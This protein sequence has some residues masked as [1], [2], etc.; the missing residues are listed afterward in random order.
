MILISEYEKSNFEFI[1]AHPGNIVF[2]GL[3]HTICFTLKKIYF[4]NYK[5]DFFTD[6]RPPVLAQAV[7]APKKRPKGKQPLELEKSAILPSKRKRPCLNYG[8]INDEDF[9]DEDFNEDDCLIKTDNLI[10]EICGFKTN[11][12]SLLIKHVRMIHKKKESAIC[13]ICGFNSTNFGLKLHVQKAHANNL[14]LKTQIES[15]YERSK[16]F[17]CK[18]CEF[19]TAQKPNLKTHIES[20]HGSIKPFKCIKCDVTS[21]HEEK[22]QRLLCLICNKSYSDMPKHIKLWHK[23]IKS[24][25]CN[26]CESETSRKA[27]LSRHKAFKCNICQFKSQTRPELDEHVVSVHEVIKPLKCNI[28]NYETVLKEYLQRHVDIVHKGIKK[29]ENK[30]NENKNNENK[31]TFMIANMPESVKEIFEASLGISNTILVNKEKEIKQGTQEVMKSVSDIDPFLEHDGTMDSLGNDFPEVNLE[32]QSDEC[33]KNVNNLENRGN[34]DCG[35]CGFK[36]NTAKSLIKHVNMNHENKETA[37]CDICGFKSTKRGVMQHVERVHSKNFICGHCE[38]KFPFEDQLKY[39]IRAKHQEVSTNVDHS[40]IKQSQISNSVVMNKEKFSK[41][42][43]INNQEVIFQSSKVKP[44]TIKQSQSS[45]T[46]DPLLIDEIKKE[47]CEENEVTPI[48]DLSE[49]SIKQVE[50]GASEY[51]NE[52]ESEIE[53]KEE[54]INPFAEYEKTIE[55]KMINEVQGNEKKS[56]KQSLDPDS[57]RKDFP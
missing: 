41:C 28:C 12:K 42:C 39:H 3:I 31:K 30:N 19:E 26:I 49:V 40:T 5:W 7:P 23:E 13:E 6:F 8:D 35:A 53:I 44:S 33:G 38:A 21:V 24:F 43:D 29:I 18:K 48:Q 20:V 51:E 22:K 45:D 9:N 2:K 1:L 4:K 10:C 37:I 15:V 56:R 17:K 36:T 11:L 54:L 47:I 32:N 16:K 57:L 50:F 27:Y 25:K 55:P 34:L 52:Q 14:D 46:T